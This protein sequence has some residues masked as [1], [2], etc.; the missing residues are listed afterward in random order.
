MSHFHEKITMGLIFKIF[1]GSHK[2]GVLLWQNCKK[3]VTF[4]GKVPKYATYFRKTLHMNIGMVLSC[5]QHIPDQSK[6]EFHPTVKC[7]IYVKVSIKVHLI[8]MNNVNRFKFKFLISKIKIDNK[9]FNILVII[10]LKLL[11]SGDIHF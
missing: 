4:W 9:H 10:D 2:F 8:F 5:W 3:W 6:S 7:S 1:W 11:W